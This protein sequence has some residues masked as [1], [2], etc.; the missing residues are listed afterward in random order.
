MGLHYK[1]KYR[2]QPPASDMGGALVFWAEEGMICILDERYPPEDP[3]H[4][5]V[6]SRR[7]WLKHLQALSAQIKREEYADERE[8]L[9]QLIENGVACAREAK[10]QGDLSD[11]K[12]VD[13]MVRHTRP[14]WSRGP[15]DLTSG[16]KN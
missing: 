1:K 8:S 3:R 15:V 14:H 12:D 16:E 7:Q 13:Y 2:W 6:L 10:R 9:L 5:T 11:P 4:L